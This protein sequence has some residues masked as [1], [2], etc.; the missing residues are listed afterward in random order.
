MAKLIDLLEKLGSDASLSGSTEELRSA[1]SE[2]EIAMLEDINHF[3]SLQPEIKCFAIVPAEDDEP[4][5]DKNDEQE[6]EQSTSAI[7]I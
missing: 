7:A 1:L 5:E 4:S 6:K 3:K 2:K